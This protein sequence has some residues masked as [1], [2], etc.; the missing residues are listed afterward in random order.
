MV[1]P[2][3]AMKTGGSRGITPL[4]LNLDDFTPQPL[5]Q[6]LLDVNV[7]TFFENRKISYSR[8]EPRTVQP[9]A[10]TLYRLR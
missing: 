6:R 1:I 8:F 3:H 7:R 2:V 4:M 10:Q 5:Y 9:V